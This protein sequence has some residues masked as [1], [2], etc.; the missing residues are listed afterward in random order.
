M[1]GSL[2]KK[3]KLDVEIK[4]QRYALD[5]IPSDDSA[6]V[7][8]E[9]ERLL[10]IIDLGAL[11]RDL[12]R[13]GNFF[14]I[15]YNAVGAAGHEY[16]KEQIEIHQLKCHTA[17]LCNESAL[18][19]AQFEYASSKI[20]NLLK[21]T[22]GYL[23][24]PLE[25][26]ATQTLSSISKIAEDMGKVALE[27]HK[28]F[29]AEENKVEETL[30]NTLRVRNIEASKIEEDKKKRIQLEVAIEHEKELIDDHQKREREAESRRRKLEQQEDQTISEIGA[31]NIRN[32]LK[33]LANAFTSLYGGRSN[34]FDTADANIRAAELRKSKFEALKIENAI[35]E[36]RQEALANMSSFLTKLKQCTNSE[37]MAEC[38]VEALHEAVGTL[39]HLSVVMMQ[40][41]TFW[42]QVQNHCY[43]LAE[44]EIKSQIETAMKI[45]EEKRLKVW[46]SHSFKVQAIGSYS[47]WVA[48][49]SVC[50]IY[51]NKIK[52]TQ[53][54][55]NRYITENP[56]SEE[57][58]GM[59]PDLAKKFLTELESDQKVLKEKN[60]EV[61]KDM[62]LLDEEE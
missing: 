55:L 54:D 16:T 33:A 11:V 18:T 5:E 14:R 49:K 15:A 34:V 56:N 17:K 23:L 42:K 1:A 29:E 47:S 46:T 7:K 52:E 51:Q 62:E 21:C 59:L 53:H 13:T 22:Y 43:S 24:E 4:G 6:I 35:R 2:N 40:A 48:L 61:Q 60:L 26:M 19:V 45:S 25:E 39:K 41:A 31:I 28:K 30:E 50:G 36:K 27:L 8:G 38:A 32:T 58:K 20:L 57:S 3:P 44:S 37:Q 12:G 9:L 10:G